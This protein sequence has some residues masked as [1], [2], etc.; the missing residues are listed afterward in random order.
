MTETVHNQSLLSL[1]AKIASELNDLLKNIP[2][3][4][5]FPIEPSDDL[6]YA[7]ELYIPPLLSSYYP[8]WESES[9]DGFFITNARKTGVGSA[10]LAGL[11]I[12]MSDQTLTPVLI[13]LVLTSSCNSVASYQVFLG[14]AGG[15]HLGISGPSCN[16]SRAQKLLDNVGARLDYIR[17]SYTITS[18]D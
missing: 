5:E 10:E 3:D 11:C 16:T 1:K 7:L 8:K 2:V 6:L 12:L 18:D 4:S 15:G 9:L 13:R 14:E 17:W